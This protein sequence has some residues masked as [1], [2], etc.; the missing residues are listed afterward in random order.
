MHWKYHHEIISFMKWAEIDPKGVDME[1]R[2]SLFDRIEYQVHQVFPKAEVVMFGST[3]S[4]F[5][6]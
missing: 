4:E 6:L 5:A 2:K 3:A 1:I